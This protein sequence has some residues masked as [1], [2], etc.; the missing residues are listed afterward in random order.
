M[1]RIKYAAASAL[2][3]ASASI[4][5]SVPAS[6]AV[7][8]NDDAMSTLATRSGCLT[9]HSIKPV[10]SSEP[11]TKPIGPAWQDVASKYKGQKGAAQ[12]LTAIVMQG[13]NPYAS[14]WKGKVSG[15]AMPPNA[16]AIHRNE[17]R[18]LVRW[19]LSLDDQKT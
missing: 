12:K 13:S 11:G 9:C 8:A 17:A 6:A 7:T 4:A 16:V 5:M 3:L 2:A 14:H 18:Q 15:L 1:K 10:S 19:I